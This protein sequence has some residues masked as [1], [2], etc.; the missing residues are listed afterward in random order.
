VTRAARYDAAARARNIAELAVMVRFG[1]LAVA[2]AAERVSRIAMADE[3]TA[4]TAAI[5]SVEIAGEVLPAWNLADLLGLDAEPQA[6]VIM[7]TSNE[8][9]APRIALGT[10]PCV[11][12]APHGAVTP[13]PIGVVSAP[14][15]AVAGV[16]ITDPALRDRGV[17]E[18]GV[19]IDPLQLIGS[20]G[21]A[22]AMAAMRRGDR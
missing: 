14:P 15:V 18:L 7:A 11:A 16:F 2:L 21:L 12:I 9:G 13:L 8:P 10:G 19:R 22:A 3:A 17:G 4:A 5:P 20:A 1:E 6:W